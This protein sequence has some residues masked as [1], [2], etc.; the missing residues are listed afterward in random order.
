MRKEWPCVL[1]RGGTSKAVFFTKNDMPRDRNNWDDFLLD[2][3][4]SPDITQIDGLGGANSLTSKVAIIS[5][6]E[7]PGFDIDYLFA[8]PDIKNRKVAWNSNCGNISS[9]VGPFAVNTGLI[10]CSS[11][12][13]SI[14]I[15]NVNTGKRI[16]SEFEISGGKALEEGDAFIPGVPGTAAPIWLSFCE[17]EGSVTGKLLPTDSPIDKI[18]TSHGEIEISIVDAAAPLV[19]A[20]ARDLDLSGTELPDQYTSDQLDLFEE[21]RAQTAQI[22]GLCRSGCGT[23]DSPAVPKMAIAAYPEDFS[24]SHGKFIEKGEMD[25]HLRMM[26]MQKPHGSVAVTGLVCTGT[27]SA[28]EGSIIWEITRGKKGTLRIAHPQGVAK[29]IPKIEGTCVQSVKILR[30][31]RRIFTGTA[32]TKKNFD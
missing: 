28:V 26:S 3:M 16:V 21:I 23:I 7:N 18:K 17:P 19:F 30:T 29:A 31:A 11:G 27:A 32:F 4:G 8:Q 6:S 13:V 2:I 25:L 12:H 14:Q 9:A 24:T 5:P 10:P 1:M 22:C 20:R 15:F